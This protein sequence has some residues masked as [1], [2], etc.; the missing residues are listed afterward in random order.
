MPGMTY[1]GRLECSVFQ[2]C[3]HGTHDVK[4]VGVLLYASVIAVAYLTSPCWSTQR[5][6]G[7][8]SHKLGG[9]TSNFNVASRGCPHAMHTCLMVAKSGVSDGLSCMPC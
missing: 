1:N 3:S 8:A 6:A 5:R 4:V 7:K 2:N 9:A